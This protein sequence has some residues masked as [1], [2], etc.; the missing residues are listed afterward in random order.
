MSSFVEM[1]DDARVRRL[2]LESSSEQNKSLGSFVN[3]SSNPSKEMR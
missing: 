2:L 3:T 1:I